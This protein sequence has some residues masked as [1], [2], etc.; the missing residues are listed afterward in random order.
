MSHDQQNNETHRRSAVFDADDGAALGTFRH[1]LM[2]AL[3]DEFRSA[4]ELMDRGDVGPFPELVE[5]T[6]SFCEF[7]GWSEEEGTGEMLRWRRGP[8][9]SVIKRAM[10]ELEE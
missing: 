10:D 4:I 8:R 7:F 9:Y 2:H 6:L 1:Q 5:H 3:D